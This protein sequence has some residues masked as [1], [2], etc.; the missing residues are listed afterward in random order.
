MNHTTN[1][2]NEDSKEPSFVR[3]I[4]LDQFFVA[5]FTPDQDLFGR[6]IEVMNER[7]L[8]RL[9]VLSGIGSLKNVTMRDLKLGIKKPVD[10]SKT[11]EIIEEG[12][13]ELLSLEGSVVPMDGEPVVHLHAVMGLPDGGVIGGHLFE[14]QVFTTLELFIAGITDIDLQ[15]KR[16]PITGLT[17]YHI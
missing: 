14:S 13:F 2:K 6:L 4:D 16:S 10:L 5:R 9:V 1:N 3:E 7:E 12:P 17:E 15:K 8:T 11:N